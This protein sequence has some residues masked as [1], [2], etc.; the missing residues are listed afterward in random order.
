[1]GVIV[2]G[3]MRVQRISYGRNVALGAAKA[4]LQLCD[5]AFNAGYITLDSGDFSVD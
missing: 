3:L 1:M 5:I 2:I 4:S